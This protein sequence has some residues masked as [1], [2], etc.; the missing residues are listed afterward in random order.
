MKFSHPLMQSNFT[1][2]DMIAA[3]KILKKKNIILINIYT[4]NG[5]PVDTDKYTYKLYWLD[6]LIK[7][8]KFFL[9]TNYIFLILLMH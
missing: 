9:S 3:T 8:L 7:K 2:S 5:N 6:S 1:N 4:P